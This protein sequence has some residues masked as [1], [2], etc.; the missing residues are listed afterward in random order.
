MTKYGRGCGKYSLRMSALTIIFLLAFLT[1]GRS[2][3][4]FPDRLTLLVASFEPLY[5]SFDWLDM[6]LEAEDKM[7]KDGFAQMR[8][9]STINLRVM[10]VCVCVCVCVCLCVLRGVSCFKCFLIAT[11]VCIY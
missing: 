3:N 7:I 4:A 9:C 1:G 6:L 10:Y 11:A 8:S 2:L 5:C